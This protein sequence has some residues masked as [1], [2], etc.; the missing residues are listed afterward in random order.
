MSY[1]TET[2]FEEKM[3]LRL[4]NDNIIL[5]LYI[6]SMVLAFVTVETYVRDSK[7]IRSIWVFS[8][9]A[10]HFIPYRVKNKINNGATHLQNT[11]F[12][13]HFIK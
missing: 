3:V 10:K 11:I 9:D 4:I 2:V 7:S 1:K 5:E 12:F 13:S 6:L 8:F